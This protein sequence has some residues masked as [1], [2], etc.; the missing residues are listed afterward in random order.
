LQ[1][2][3]RRQAE[4][5]PGAVALS[6]SNNSVNWRRHHGSGCVNFGFSHNGR[7]LPADP[8]ACFVMADN[9]ST[10]L[11]YSAPQ[12]DVTRDIDLANP[13]AVLAAIEGIFDRRFG[14]AW[15]REALSTA[16]TDVVRAYAG[17]YPGLLVCDTPYHDLRHT[18]DTTLAMARIIDGHEASR[19]RQ[20]APLGAELAVVGVLLAVF[21]DFGYLR[22][23]GEEHLTG[24]QLVGG[25][26]TRG[27]EFAAAF[28][29]RNGLAQHVPLARLILATAF[30]ENLNELFAAYHGAAV[31]LACMMASADVLSQLADRYY[32]ER[33]RDFL[34]QEF[35]EGG[36]DRVV[37]SDGVECI[38][39]TSAEDLLRKT[40]WF[41]EAVIIK[42]LEYELR[43]VYRYLD[44][45]FGGQNPYV[46]AMFANITFL[47]EL[48]DSDDFARLRRNPQPLYRVA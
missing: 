24:A 22:R 17:E 39:Y 6:E 2:Y 25:H 9:L 11:I 44:D 42:R 32:L 19:L 46:N 21:H 1:C 45:H 12:L 13:A 40:P 8:Q 26:E 18:L 23:T 14:D 41:F 27:A 35:V 3:C 28:L 37:Q 5:G 15:P 29:S 34:F 47:K 33:C 43:G 4:K 38:L 10:D 7:Y 20:G 36:L 16:I 48:V 30:K 31:D